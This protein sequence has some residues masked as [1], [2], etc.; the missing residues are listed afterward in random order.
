MVKKKIDKS[1]SSTSRCSL[2]VSFSVLILNSQK[3]NAW[4]FIKSVRL[5]IFQR[6][7]SDVP[8]TEVCNRTKYSDIHILK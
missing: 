3:K 8:A 1:L 6:A 5:E 2:K 4:Y 7:G